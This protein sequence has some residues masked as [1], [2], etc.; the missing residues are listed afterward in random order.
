MSKS[1]RPFVDFRAIRARVTTESVLEHYNL[2]GTFKRSAI[3]LSTFFFDVVRLRPH[4]RYKV[5]ALFGSTMPAADQELIHKHPKR[6]SEIIVM[7]DEYDAGLVE[8]HDI[9]GYVAKFCLV[10]MHR[11]EKLCTQPEHLSAEEATQLF[12]GVT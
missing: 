2:L 4:S 11:I 9:V 5:V 6:Q 7:L 8:R 10:K 3:R 12:G 1:K